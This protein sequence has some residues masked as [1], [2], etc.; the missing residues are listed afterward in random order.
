MRI[1][2]G[3]NI[4]A[5]AIFDIVV[6]GYKDIVA[7]A[8][9][10]GLQSDY[11]K[12]L[13][14]PISTPTISTN[15]STQCPVWDCSSIPTTEP[16]APHQQAWVQ[17]AKYAT[18]THFKT[19]RFDEHGHDPD[20]DIPKVIGLLKAAGYNGCWGIKKLPDRWR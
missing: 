12:P 17:Y 1:D 13:G 8:Q 2:A 11:R 16:L 7:R 14:A 6:D 10:L 15:C 4:A 5:E 20:Q 18:A 3:G 19:F 9:P